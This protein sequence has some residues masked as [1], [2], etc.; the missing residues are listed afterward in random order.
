M[1]ESLR[2]QLGECYD[3]AEIVAQRYD[4]AK[5]YSVYSSDIKALFR[6]VCTRGEKAVLHALERLEEYWETNLSKPKRQYENP[7]PR[8]SASA[9]AWA[10]G[11]DG[12][13]YKSEIKIQ[14][15]ILD[16]YRD[17]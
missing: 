15:M 6:H 3:R 13:S 4:K 14:R 5:T 12:D 2:E 11:K 1:L 9:A 17:Q 10:R 8:D 16:I 7:F